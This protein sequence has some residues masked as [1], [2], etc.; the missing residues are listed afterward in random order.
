L[1][2]LGV[3]VD[4]SHV[5]D[6]TFYDVIATTRAPVIASHSSARALAAHP[7]NMTDDMLRAVAKN[8]GVVMVNFVVTFLDETYRRTFTAPP[9]DAAARIG[10]L[11]QRCGSDEACALVG[12][13]RLLRELMSTGILPPVSWTSI[14]DHLEHVVRVAG[15]NHVGLGSDFDGATTPLGMDDVTRLPRITEELLRRGYSSE[16]VRKIVGGNILRVM[17]EVQAVGRRL[18]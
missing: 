7:R 1:N 3:M 15:I 17:G 11:N 2:R 12:G 6:D 13:D 9:A 5:S 16:A 8:N 18:R 10:A 4:V 14:V